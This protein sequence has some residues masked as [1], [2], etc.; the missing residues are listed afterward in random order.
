MP[1]TPS[2]LLYCD[3]L[4]SQ[5]T[6]TQEGQDWRQSFDS[7]EDAYEYAESRVTGKTPL[8]LY[9][10][11]REMIL[12]TAISPLAA[13]LSSARDSKRKLAVAD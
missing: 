10:E 8:I 1:F 7:F 5:F 9:N 4:K 6:L 2:F 13:E 12:K 3:N 11:R